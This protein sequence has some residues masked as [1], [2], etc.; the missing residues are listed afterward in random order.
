MTK[1][2]KEPESKIEEANN[3]EAN[4]SEEINENK[5]NNQMDFESKYKYAL[6][7]IENIKKRS[8]KEI[9]NTK[10]FSNEKILKSL[11]ETLD[12]FDRTLSFVDNN[13]EKNKN[14]VDGIKMV[15]NQMLK[16]LEKFGLK[17][18]EINLNETKFDPN[19]H[20][21]INVVKNPNLEDETI[22][23]ILQKGYMLEDRLL[24][25]AKVSLVKN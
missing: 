12:N 23:M 13:D 22:T 3:E 8:E 19:F 15:Q 10:R 5:E 11:I 7:E 17:L 21:A 16:S 1:E 9:A 24:R 25:A 6:A 2:S 18:V 14:I 4:L 20:E